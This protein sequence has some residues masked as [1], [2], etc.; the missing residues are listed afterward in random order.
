M[1]SPTPA[2]SAAAP[3]FLR[4]A[5]VSAITT[6]RRSALYARIAA[7]SFPR[8]RQISSRCSVWLASEVYEWVAAQPVA[9]G[10]RPGSRAATAS[11]A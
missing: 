4:L 10:P 1:D 9:V 11:A 3:R 2:A 8:P 7:G 6:L 5:E